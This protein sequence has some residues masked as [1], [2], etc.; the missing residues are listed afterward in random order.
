LKREK[1]G[2]GIY[3][4]MSKKITK[5]LTGAQK[6]LLFR[7][8]GVLGL[9]LAVPFFLWFILGSLGVIPS[10]VDVFGIVGLRTPAA[11]TVAGLLMAAIGF[12]D[13]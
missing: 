2:S 9:V 11:F 12:Y 6:Q 4:T 3:K 1:A 5:F 8:I 7:S 13:K 10:L